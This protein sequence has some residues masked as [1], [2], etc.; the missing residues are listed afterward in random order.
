[1]RL[2]PSLKR[3]IAFFDGQNLFHAAREAFGYTFPN[4]NPLTLSQLICLKQNWN[5]SEVNF[6]TGIPRKENDPFWYDFWIIKLAAMGTTG[7][8]TF[9]RPIRYQSRIVSLPDGSV[10]KI[11]IGQEKGIDVRIALD[12]VRKARHVEFDVALIFSQDQDLSEVA[13]EV[14]D[15]SNQQDRWIKLACAFPVNLTLKKNRG[16]NGMDWIPITMEMY[17][18]CIDPN[19]YRPKTK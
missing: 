8:K 7:I 16:I 13:D 6:Y 12:V 3:T 2:E 11:S 14:R 15:I 4:F 5:L 10:R 18:S 1:M 17:D 19:D 9:S